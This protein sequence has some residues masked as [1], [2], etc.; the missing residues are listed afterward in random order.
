MCGISDDSG[1]LIAEA[2]KTNKSMMALFLRE[3]SLHDYTG[4]ILVE[5]ARE[6]Q[7]I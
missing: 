2:I 7:N 5:A 4:I 1:M 6:N 3:N